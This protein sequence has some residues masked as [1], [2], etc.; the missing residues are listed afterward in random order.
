[1]AVRK[2]FQLDQEALGKAVA[3]P[4]DRLGSRW[5]PA[6]FEPGGAKGRGSASGVYGYFEGMR[7][8]DL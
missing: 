2:L 4:G 8:G 7:V 3:E 1:M 5:L 6:L